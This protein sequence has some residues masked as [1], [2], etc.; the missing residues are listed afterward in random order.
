MAFSRVNHVLF[1]RFLNSVIS[2]SPNI[3][4]EKVDQKINKKCAGRLLLAGLGWAGLGWLG[5]IHTLEH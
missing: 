2:R 1:F 4:D 3:F 5:S